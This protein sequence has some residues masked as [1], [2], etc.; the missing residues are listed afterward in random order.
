MLVSVLDDTYHKTYDIE[1]F[2]KLK[3]K[4]TSKLK[5]GSQEYRVSRGELIL[6]YSSVY[7]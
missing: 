2:T 7:Y 6:Q 1:G 4:K 3:K 5:L